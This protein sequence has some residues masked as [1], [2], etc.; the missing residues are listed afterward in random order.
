M[1]H[2]RPTRR[3]PVWQLSGRGIQIPTLN[4]Y[5]RPSRFDLFLYSKLGYFNVS[6]N[7]DIFY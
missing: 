5:F 4:E 7:K 2:Q 1:A 3:N 6:Q